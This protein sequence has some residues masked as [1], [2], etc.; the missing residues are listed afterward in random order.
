MDVVGAHSPEADREPRI[1]AWT[2][3]ISH[4]EMLW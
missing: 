3:I 4:D 1:R 2:A